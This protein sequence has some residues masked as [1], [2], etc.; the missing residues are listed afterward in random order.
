MAWNTARGVDNIDAIDRIDRVDVIDQIDRIDWRLKV[1]NQVNIVNIVNPVKNP[2]PKN[3]PA[4]RPFS[5]RAEFT[6]MK[7]GAAYCERMMQ[8][9]GP[10]PMLPL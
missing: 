2:P 9:Y 7:L 4:R 8:E 1:V 5:P 6:S 3:N 10:M